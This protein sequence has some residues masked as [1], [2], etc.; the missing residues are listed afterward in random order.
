M[1]KNQQEG[2]G[3]VSEKEIVG[4]DSY[5]R[6]GGKGLNLASLGP[7]ELQSL[8]LTWG[9]FLELSVSPAATLQ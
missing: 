7:D 1:F 6:A 5:W 3:G 8:Q 2:V 4:E 9:L